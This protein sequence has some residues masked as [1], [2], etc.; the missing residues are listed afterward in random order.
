MAKS[1]SVFLNLHVARLHALE[2][3]L[4]ISLWLSPENKLQYKT[5]KTEF[6]NY[7][8]IDTQICHTQ[9]NV[10][11]KEKKNREK[12]IFRKPSI[13]TS[14]QFE[15]T[16]SMDS[17]PWHLSSYWSRV[18]LGPWEFPQQHGYPLD[19]KL[20]IDKNVLYFMWSSIPPLLPSSSAV[21]GI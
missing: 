12:N 11:R 3:M 20:L 1:H 19:Y 6:K 21:D 13:F 10:E 7:I 9:A 15:Q 17:Y 2:Q 14:P 18:V 16:C 5:L 8:Y 4:T